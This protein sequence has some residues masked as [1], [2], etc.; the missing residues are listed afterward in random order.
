MQDSSQEKSSTGE[1][2]ISTE[3]DDNLNDNI[4]T[5]TGLATGGIG[6][7]LE[8]ATGGLM[9]HIGTIIFVIVA[10]IGLFFLFNLLT[11]IAQKK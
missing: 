10:G 9:K 4:Q 1:G 11:S 3:Y 7:A 2:V 8:G 5:A 6:A